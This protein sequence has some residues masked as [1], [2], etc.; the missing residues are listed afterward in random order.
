MPIV[1]MVV[2]KRKIAKQEAGYD[3][4]KNLQRLNQV[5]GSS[6]RSFLADRT[7]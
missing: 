1:L 7:A 6:P 2:K 4:L 3:P 5:F